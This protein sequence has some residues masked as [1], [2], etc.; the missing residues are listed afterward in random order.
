VGD[1]G[2]RARKK[3]ATGELIA[4][5]ARAL[6]VTRGFEKVSV[7]E[8][9]RAADVA[10]TTVFNYFPRKEDLVYWR[11]DAFEAELLEAVRTR[12]SGET[13]VDAFG[14]FVSKPRGL[15]AE[16]EPAVV[17]RLAGIARMITD[18]PDLLAR[19]REIFD[20]YTASLAELLAAE[21]GPSVGYVSSW[22]AANALIGVH[23]AITDHTR[24]QVNAG[25]RNQALARSV[26]AQARR[27]V[28]TVARGLATWPND[29]RGQQ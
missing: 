8:I 6:F 16:T 13:V 20:R 19:E 2:R 4:E 23:R 29:G 3:Q 26:R 9:A 12:P 17:E 10:E 22:V 25:V 15:L 21:A 27:A 5:T 7:A 1:L 11:T 18:S 24:A 28:A 14:R